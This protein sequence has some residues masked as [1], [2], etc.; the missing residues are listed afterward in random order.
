MEGRGWGRRGVARSARLFFSF[1]LSSRG[2]ELIQAFGERM[3]KEENDSSVGFESGREELIHLFYSYLSCPPT[4]PTNMPTEKLCKLWQLEQDKD[5]QQSFPALFRAEP[6]NAG[7]LFF[8]AASWILF[9]VFS[10]GCC[11]TNSLKMLNALT[12]HTLLTALKTALYWKKQTNKKLLTICNWL[13]L[14]Y[15]I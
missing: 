4:P 6:A 7:S 15:W 12:F 10:M 11:Q 9:S 1:F 5:A 14:F 3:C 8:F 13:H 2:Q